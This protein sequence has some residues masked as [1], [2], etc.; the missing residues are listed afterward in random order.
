[1]GDSWEDEDF[2][3]PI[4]TGQLNAIVQDDEEDLTQSE[5][6]SVP[7]T[8]AKSASALKREEELAAALEN[9]IKLTMEAN[10]T[11]EERKIREKKQAEESDTQLAGELFQNDTNAATASSKPTSSLASLPLKTKQDH[12][13]FGVMVSQRLSISSPFNLAAYYKSLSK[14]L[15]S[16]EMSLE[17]LDQIIA[18]IQVI[19]EDK[20]RVT[21]K[22][23]KTTNKK[24]SKKEIEQEE[25]K[26][27]DKYNDGDI[28]TPVSK[29]DYLNDYEDDYM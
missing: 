21:Q 2:E 25:K 11:A 27:A 10:E 29:Y 17:V 23:N 19:R 7:T 5:K 15:V 14:V 4:L 12:S 24:K 22:A 16:P 3:I 28:Q 8:V 20:A 26:H 6:Q 18:D 1:M 9:K 13:N